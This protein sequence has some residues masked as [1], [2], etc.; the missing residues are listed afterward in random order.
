MRNNSV[1]KF[2]FMKRVLWIAVVVE[3]GRAIEDKTNQYF[4]VNYSFIFEWLACYLRVGTFLFVKFKIQIWMQFRYLNWLRRSLN[5]VLIIIRVSRLCDSVICLG[6]FT[7]ISAIKCSIVL[8]FSV[9]C[10]CSA[11]AFDCT[12]HLQ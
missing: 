11:S 3:C 1:I 8:L 10:S 6:H 4:R 12:L 5:V 7:F 9:Q 2:K